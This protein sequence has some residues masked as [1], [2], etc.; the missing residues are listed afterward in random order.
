MTDNS[1][2]DA[3]MEAVVWTVPRVIGHNIRVKRESMGISQAELGQRIGHYSG[4]AWTRQQVFNAEKGSRSF[5]ASEVA[6]VSLATGLVPA[7]LFQPPPEALAIELAEGHNV[8]AGWLSGPVDLPAAAQQAALQANESLVTLRQAGPQ[9]EALT[10]GVARAA[11]K[12]FQSLSL[13]RDMRA[14][15]ND[16]S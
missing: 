1:P 8:S 2:I 6:V 16:A 9:Y 4:S 13:L 7:L 14:S 12:L 10:E 5:T 3:D 11:E 15:K